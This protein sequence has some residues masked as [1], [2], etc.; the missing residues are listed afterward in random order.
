MQTNNAHTELQP[1]DHS[2]KLRYS[3]G[4]SDAELHARQADPVN[5]QLPQ[6]EVGVDLIV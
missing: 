5:A 4:Q 3:D 1:M 2:I 6:Q